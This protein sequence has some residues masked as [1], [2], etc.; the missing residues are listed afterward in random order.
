LLA[1]AK[2]PASAYTVE[3]LGIAATFAGEVIGL[4]GVNQ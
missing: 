1:N 4:C 2:G 3:K